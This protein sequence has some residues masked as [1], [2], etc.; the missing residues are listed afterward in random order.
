[1][2]QWRREIETLADQKHSFVEVFRRLNRDVR[3]QKQIEP[4]KTREANKFHAKLPRN[5]E[6][7]S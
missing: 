4:R 2:I 6:E 7:S 1:M 5:G 3:I